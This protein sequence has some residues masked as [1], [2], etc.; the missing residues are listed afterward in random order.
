MSD[1]LASP[2]VNVRSAADAPLN[3]L[4]SSFRRNPVYQPSYNG[5]RSEFQSAFR[6]A[7]SQDADKYADGVSEPDHL[8]RIVSIADDLTEQFAPL[9]RNGRMRIGTVQKGLNLFLKIRWCLDRTGFVVPPHC[10]IDRGVLQEVGIYDSWTDLDD[11]DTYATWI[12][13]LRSKAQAQR[14][15]LSEWELRVWGA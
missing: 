5:D 14:M 13:T 8:N 10:P 15:S 11:I 6:T 1:F 12:S 9:L 2:K 4:I 3:A 7:V